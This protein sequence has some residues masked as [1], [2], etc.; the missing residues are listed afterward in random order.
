MVFCR[1]LVMIGRDGMTLEAVEDRSHGLGCFQGIRGKLHD[2]IR[3]FRRQVNSMTG[4]EAA[5]NITAFDGA[6]RMSMRQQCLV[7]PVL[8]V[9]PGLEMFRGLTMEP[10][11]FGMVRCGGRMMFRY[12]MLGGHDISIRYSVKREPKPRCLVPE[13]DGLDRA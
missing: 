5:S 12:R 10:G 9:L 8:W 2:P 1:F 7:R 4:I 3:I 11:R 13:I 6:Q